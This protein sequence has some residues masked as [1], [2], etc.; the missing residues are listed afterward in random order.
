MKLTLAKIAELIDGELV[1]DGSVEINGVGK[2]EDAHKGQITFISN[3]KYAKFIETSGAS[4][5]IVGEDF[6][7]R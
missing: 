7:E 1:G 4:A 6:P 5:I 3:A 2:I